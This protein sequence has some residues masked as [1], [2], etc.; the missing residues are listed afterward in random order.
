MEPLTRVEGIAYVRFTAPD[1]QEMEPSLNEFGLITRE[2]DGCLYGI[3]RDGASFARVTEAG[4]PAFRALG[5]RAESIDE[6][7]RLAA[8]E[9]VEVKPLSAPGGGVI[10]RLIDPDG[11]TVEVV[12]GQLRGERT[13]LPREPVRNSA[14]LRARLC[15]PVRVDADRSTVLRLGH[16]VLNVADSRRSEVWYKKQFHFITPDEIEVAPGFATMPGTTS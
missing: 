15:E 12:A 9:G 3:G 1:L 8:R 2:V 5:L 10:A 16:C 13:V 4:E 7:R 6:V 14:A 11:V